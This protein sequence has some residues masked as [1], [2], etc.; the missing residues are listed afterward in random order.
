MHLCTRP[1]LCRLSWPK[2]LPMTAFKYSSQ[3]RYC[4]ALVARKLCHLNAAR[5]PVHLNM[6][7]DLGVMHLTL[8]HGRQLHLLIVANTSCTSNRLGSSSN[9]NCGATA[10]RKQLLLSTHVNSGRQFALAAD[11]PREALSP[12]YNTNISC[13]AL[14][15][16]LPRRKRCACT[17]A[18]RW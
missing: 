16:Q 3:E 14:M 18:Q 10:V 5:Q 7:V 6:Q 4:I 8:A 9:M 2:L 1:I 17:P 15:L 12:K 13:L 11:H